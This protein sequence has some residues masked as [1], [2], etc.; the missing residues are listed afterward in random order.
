M[1]ASDDYNDFTNIREIAKKFP[2][3][4]D[5]PTELELQ[6]IEVGDSI[7]VNICG[8]FIWLDVRRYFREQTFGMV[9]STPKNTK[10][11]GISLGDRV[12]V[13]TRNIYEIVKPAKI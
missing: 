7:K 11:H 6:E 10:T 13:L 12:G 9:I 3:Q 4:L 5:V 1:R 8:D 2:G